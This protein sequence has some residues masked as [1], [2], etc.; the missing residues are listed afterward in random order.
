MPKANESELRKGKGKTCFSLFSAD[1]GFSKQTDLYE[2]EGCGPRNRITSGLGKPVY[3][4]FEMHLRDLE[5][6]LGET[7]A[8]AYG[9]AS[10]AGNQSE[11]RLYIGWFGVLMI[12]TLLTAT[13]VFIIAFIAAPPVDIDALV[14]C[15]ICFLDLPNWSRKLLDGQNH[16]HVILQ[17]FQDILQ[18]RNLAKVRDEEARRQ[19]REEGE[20]KGLIQKG[21]D[22]E[23]LGRFQRPRCQCRVSHFNAGKAS[24]MKVVAAPLQI[25]CSIHFI[26]EFRPELLGTIFV[27][28]YINHYSHLKRVL[29]MLGVGNALSINPMYLNDQIGYDKVT[30]IF[31]RGLVITAT[32][33]IQGNRY[34]SD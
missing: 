10:V 29:H 6:L 5:L 15:Y 27:V 14:G 22:L 19:R 7:K 13:S 24:G 20:G 1:R 30:L 32:Q 34:S 23:N 18:A 4:G 8:K 33:V 9:V 12:P 17:A 16:L 2:N 25:M 31:A 11:N 26:L 21:K 3:E 28:L